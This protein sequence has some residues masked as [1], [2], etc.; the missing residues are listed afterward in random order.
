MPTR[1]TRATL[2]RV[3]LV[4]RPAAVV[5]TTTGRIAAG[6]TALRRVAAVALLITL[7]VAL[8]VLTLLVTLLIALLISVL[9][10]VGTLRIA[11]R[12]LARITRTVVARV[13]TTA[14]GAA[15]AATAGR[16]EIVAALLMMMVVVILIV[17]A[18]QGAES[19]TDSTAVE[20]T[21]GIETGEEKT[22]DAAGQGAFSSPIGGSVLLRT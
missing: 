13:V 15:I 21:D 18:D 8:L 12:V 11:A 1:V 10:V 4:L 2:G 9:G 5:P 3:A 19:R 16:R 14:L 17:A 7:L 22:G 6:I 20:G